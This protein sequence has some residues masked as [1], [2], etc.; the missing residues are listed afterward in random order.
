VSKRAGLGVLTLAGLVLA[1]FGLW[2]LSHLGLSGS[3]SFS[4]KPS[5]S[6]IVVLE[7]SVLNRVDSPVTI[8]AKAKD[9][10]EVWVARTTPSDATSLVGKA[11]TTSVTGVSLGGWQLETGQ[12]GAGTAP[13]LASADLWRQQV[14]GR[15][16]ASMT[17]KQENAPETVVI[18]TASG[19]PADL[20]D[21]TVRWER[22]LWSVEAIAAL[23]L[24]L[25]MAAAGVIGLVRLQRS[26]AVSRPAP[27]DPPPTPSTSTPSTPAPSTST[28]STST[29]STPTA[30]LPVQEPAATTSEE[31][32]P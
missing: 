2:F 10:S 19:K 14:T 5:N 12:R 6:R 25:S 31:G 20:S 1:G 7:P 16:T 11:A 9:G 17:V 21:L 29:P 3:G 22:P 15:G 27:Q 30:P 32:R 18:A 23:L 4:A 13:A 8:T 28:P 24:G 26:D